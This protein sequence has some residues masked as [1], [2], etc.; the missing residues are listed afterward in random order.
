MKSKLH[1]SRKLKNVLKKLN[2]LVGI[3]FLICCF[4][5]AKGQ[6]VSPVQGGHY[7]PGVKNIRDLA[8]PPSGLFVLWYNAY[9]H[10]NKYYDKNGNGLTNI[11]ISNFLP[12]LH[13]VEV[14]TDLSAFTSIPSIFWASNATVLGEAKYLAGISVNYFSADASFITERS[15]IIGDNTYTNTFEGKNSGFTDLF[16]APV[17]LSWQV[18]QF[19]LTFMYGFYAPTGKYTSGSAD[20]IGLGFWTHQ[21]QGYGYYYPVE[22]KSTAL[23]F[24]LTFE[25]NSKIKD[26]DV[27][28]G[29]RFSLEW[30]ISQYL[31]ERLELGIM[32]GHNWQV[33]RD[34]GEDVYWNDSYYDRKSTINANFGYWI[35]KEHMQLNLKYGFDFGMQQRFRN[36][37]VL[38]N[39]LFIPDI[40]NGK[41]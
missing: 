19:D 6:Q 2:Q 7:A 34:K 31:T 3:V 24:G 41:E 40:L 35:M 17:G 30:G 21:F 39:L 33:T 5:P 18:D 28:P 23:M 27:K 4:I 12:N 16:I 29:N 26:M 8:T 38:L 14:N 37:S 22:D 10:S 20:N 11:P 32:G 15:G 1:T 36:N 9:V 25:A 13:D